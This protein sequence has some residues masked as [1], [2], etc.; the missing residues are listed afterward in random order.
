MEK[1]NMN[2]NVEWRMEKYTKQI[3]IGKGLND[4]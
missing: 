3:L 1:S 4:Q 2:P